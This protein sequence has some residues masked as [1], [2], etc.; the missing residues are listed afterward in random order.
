MLMTTFSNIAHYKVKLR[1]LN[2]L[3]IWDIIN[4]GVHIIN[5]SN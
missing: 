5:N 3:I 4:N 1:V 2:L